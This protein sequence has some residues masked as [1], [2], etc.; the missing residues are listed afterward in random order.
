[1]VDLDAALRNLLYNFPPG[2]IRAMYHT[3]TYVPTHPHVPA[4]SPLLVGGAKRHATAQEYARVITAMGLP[5]AAQSIVAMME[6]GS[7]RQARQDIELD[8]AN[9]AGASDPWAVIEAIC[10]D[11]DWEMHHPNPGC[12]ICHHIL[13]D[14]VTYRYILFCSLCEPRAPILTI[15]HTTL[16]PQAMWILEEAVPNTSGCFYALLPRSL[17]V[18]RIGERGRP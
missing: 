9:G 6:K 3:H 8:K 5:E 15:T 2:T 17:Q 14:Y 4:P 11:P 18:R 10:N 1:M 7:K 12:I 16:L 13:P